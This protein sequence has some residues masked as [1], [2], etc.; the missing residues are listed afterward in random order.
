MLRP[1]GRIVVLLA[2][3]T[4]L[5]A[6]PAAQVSARGAEGA[7]PPRVVMARVGKR[8]ITVSDFMRYIAQDA[9]R[10]SGATQV[11]GRAALLRELIS[12]E[13]LREGMQREGFLPK[14]QKP[15]QGAL[16]QAQQN[17][18]RKH[19]FVPPVT[20]EQALLGYYNSH[21]EQFGI[22]LSVRVTQIQFRIPKGANAAQIAAIKGRAEQALKRL[23]T[24]EDVSALAA[25]LTE[26]THAKATRGDLGFLPRN[27]DPWLSKALDGVSVGGHSQVVTSPSTFEILAITDQRPAVTV[28]FQEARKAVEQRMRLEESTRLKDDYLRKMAREVGVTIEMKEL[29][30]GAMP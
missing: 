18:A 21:K 29:Q 17:F 3:L 5:Q 27:A 4:W 14:N 15:S 1:L 23:E 2:A 26:N 6:T 16:I 8:E 12:L 25:E 28:P 10:A 22:P 13:L 19:F 24:G 20:S 9:S 30:A 7:A 11:N